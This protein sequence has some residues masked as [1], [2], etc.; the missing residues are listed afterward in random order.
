MVQPS[1]RPVLLAFNPFPAPPTAS[2]SLPA[3]QARAQASA[4]EEQTP[5]TLVATT[6]PPTEPQQLVSSQQDPDPVSLRPRSPRLPRTPGFGLP[7]AITTRHIPAEVRRRV[8]QRDGGQCT[9]V[10][11]EGNRC[12]ERRFLQIE[13]RRPYARGGPSTVENCCLLCAG[14]NQF[15]AR[16]SF[17]ETF[18]GVAKV[19]AS[20][21]RGETRQSNSRR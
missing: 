19:C 18:M 4:T 10:G 21:Q 7:V 3:Q 8:W 13:H 20:A 14:H 6:N 16:E 5:R 2:L 15:R 11:S 9:F 1:G 12:E 17:G